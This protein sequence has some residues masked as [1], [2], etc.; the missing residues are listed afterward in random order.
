M[1]LAC[2]AVALAKAGH[3]L[4]NASPARALLFAMPHVHGS[5]FPRP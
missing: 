2:R 4:K 3:F 1:S 5:L